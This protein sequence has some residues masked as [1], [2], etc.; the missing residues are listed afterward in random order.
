[1]K[2]L[3]FI[4]FIT[5]F[6]LFALNPSQAIELIKIDLN[7]DKF[8]NGEE[9]R[10]VIQVANNF[11]ILLTGQLLCN[12]SS[13]DPNLPPTPQV[14][15]INLEPGKKSDRLEC[16]TL[17]TETMPEG[18]YRVEVE[19]RDQNF[20]IITE[21]NKEFLVTGTKKE[22][23]AELLICADQDCQTPKVVFLQGENIFLKLKSTLTDLDIKGTIKL[24]NSQN[25]SE[26]IFKDNISG[27][28]SNSIGSYLV[29]LKL[30][31]AGYVEKIIDQDF[32]VI[33][34]PVK[35]NSASLCDGNGQCSGQENIQNC[36]QDCYVKYKSLVTYLTDI[37][38]ISLIIIAILVLAAI[39]AAY[40]FL[41]RKNKSI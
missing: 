3:F 31:K 19:L 5:S 39:L 23:N 20:N 10:A 2:K 11:S 7:K 28:K 35:I 9:V 36:P 34:Q 1:M 37:K 15:P 26:L 4:F 14:W 8:T 27:F 38:I 29:N 40:Y 6:L 33:A 30:N 18:F 41:I 21:T 17:I 24:A 16:S 13:P 32:A 12:F 25:S 22:I